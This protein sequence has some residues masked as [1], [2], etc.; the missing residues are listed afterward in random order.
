M[1]LPFASA[2]E[3]PLQKVIASLNVLDRLKNTGHRIFSAEAQTNICKQA[4]WWMPSFN[5]VA[6]T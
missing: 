2:A 1:R 4:I 5:A 3:H 6:P